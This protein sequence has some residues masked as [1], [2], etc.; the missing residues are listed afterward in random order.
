MTSIDLT[1]EVSSGCTSSVGEVETSSPW[2]VTT[3]SSGKVPMT[4]N[5]ATASEQTTQ[6]M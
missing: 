6:M 3:R 5:I 4:M 2:E 1:M